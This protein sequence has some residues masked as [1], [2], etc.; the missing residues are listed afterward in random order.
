M[1]FLPNCPVRQRKRRKNKIQ[2]QRNRYIMR[3]ILK[4]AKAELFTLFYSP[5]AWLILVTFAVQVGLT[6]MEL[7]KDCV[8][9]EEM[10]YGNTFLTAMIF[11]SRDGVFNMVQQYLYLYMP[12]LTMGLMSRE[13]S[14]GSIKLLYSSPVTSFHIIIG[15]FSA[16]MAYGGI[17]LSTLILYIGYTACVVENFVFAEVIPGILGL[18]LLLCAYAAI[19]LFVSSLTSYQVGA[20]ITTLI[21]LSV[22]NY[23]N[24]VW[25]GVVFVRDITY[26]LCLSGRTADM[27]GGLLSSDD[28]LYFVIVIVM[29]LSLSILKLQSMRQRVSW[30]VVWGKYIGVI[31]VAVLLGFVTSRPMMLRYYD[32]TE[33]KRNTLTP[34]SQDIIR[35]L[36]G[37]MTITTYVNLLDPN[38]FIGMPERVNFDLERFKQY[39]QFK[40]EIKMKYVY[41]YDSVTNNPWL[42]VRFPN[43]T[44]KEKAAQLA[45][46]KN[47][48]FKMFMPPEEIKKIVNLSGEGN[49]FVRIVER[50]NGQ[51][52]FLRLFNDMEQFPGEGEMA[53]MFKR[54]IMKMPKIG[55]LT[56]HGERSID[57]ERSK[58]YHFF[59]RMRNFRYSLINQGFDVETVSLAENSDIPKDVEIVVIADMEK[60]LMPEEQEKLDQ[61]IARGGNLVIAGE[62]GKQEIMNPL[63]EQFG[64]RFLPGELVQVK[65]DIQSNLMLVRGT[66][67]AGTISYFFNGLKR[68]AKIVMNGVT[69]LAYTEDKGFKVTEVLRTDSTGCWNEMETRDFVHDSVILNPAAG[70]V[71]AMYPVAL[72]LSREVGE[73]EQRIMILGDAD[74]ISNV[75]FSTERGW[76]GIKV[77]NYTLVTGTFHWLSYGE[78]PADVRRPLGTDNKLYLSRKALPY[79]NMACT[80]GIPVVL[81]LLGVFLWMRRKRK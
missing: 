34:V 1:K 61:Y 70:E 66:P 23:M 25:Q 39:L 3:R 29:F 27:I 68:Y 22:L 78:S 20:A 37:K 58:D 6:F 12:L 41:Y 2:I 44:L 17:L 47:R 16:M 24:Q 15:K 51:K 33:T 76:P 74:C 45:E 80:G 79:L 40:P 43:M 71:E 28:V 9:R 60:T 35:Q 4:I 36:D 73:R 11:G 62:V 48:N 53:V 56:G 63:V 19:G 54:F 10:G 65:E 26:W 31:I 18:Y 32:M 42:D 81:L 59:S 52:A 5:V 21:I 14:S 75:E 67:E 46:L 49:E 38:Y 77:S 55:F 57:S 13:Y 50:E 64:V 72:A 7:M 69:G 30:T 8:Y